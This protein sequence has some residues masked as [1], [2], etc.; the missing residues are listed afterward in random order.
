MFPRP[1]QRCR[2]SRPTPCS[3]SHCK[4]PV[5]PAKKPGN[6]LV[7]KECCG[8]L[9][10]QGKQPGFQ[11]WGAAVEL[12]N[13][14]AQISVYSNPTSTDIL[15]VEIEGTE[16]GHLYVP[17]GNT[18]NFLSQGIQSVKISVQGNEHT[19][20]EGKY[21]VSITLDLPDTPASDNEQ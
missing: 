3:S 17:P 2:Q 7:E 8:N 14:V 16:K 4:D 6:R 12:G 1:P 10:I 5:D 20:V 21:V 11:I 15:E 18:V 19:Y 9:L 13:R